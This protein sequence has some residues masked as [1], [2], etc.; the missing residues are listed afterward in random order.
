M[1]GSPRLSPLCAILA[2]LDFCLGVIML[3]TQFSCFPFFHSA[4]ENKHFPV[5]LQTL[6]KHHFNS[7]T[8]FYPARY[9]GLF[10]F[11]PPVGHVDFFFPVGFF[12]R[13][14]YKTS[15]VFL[16]LSVW[17]L[18]QYLRETPSLGLAWKSRAVNTA[19]GDTAFA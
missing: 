12:F 2:G 15:L 11:L 3:N 5:L 6:G 13:H 1:C 8:I 10:N 18:Y 14:K 16:F 19:L 4:F 17:G 9:H 7:C